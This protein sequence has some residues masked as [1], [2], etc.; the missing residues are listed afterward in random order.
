MPYVGVSSLRLTLYGRVLST[1]GYN[2]G[3]ID[4]KPVRQ[5]FAKNCRPI[6]LY[7]ELQIVPHVI[8]HQY[9]PK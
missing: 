3:E 7:A 6:P 1:V 9:R 8:R 5:N 2:A 4:F